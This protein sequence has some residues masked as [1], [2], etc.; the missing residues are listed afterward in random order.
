MIIQYSPSPTVSHKTGRIIVKTTSV[1]I[2]KS[3]A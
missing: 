2:L 3:A 1:V